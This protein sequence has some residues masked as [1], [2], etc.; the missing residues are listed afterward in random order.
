MSCCFYKGDSLELLRK[1]QSGTIDF[2]YANPP[3]NTTMQPW[4]TKQDWPAIFKE[5]FRILK[6]DGMIALHCSVPFNYELI[7]SAPKPPV[8]SWYWHK[9]GSPTGYLSSNHQPLRV[10][11]EILIF[12]KKKTKYYR[13]Q[14]GEEPHDS[15]TATPTAYTLP[16]APRKKTVVIG[17][18][19]THFLQ[20]KRDV[21]GFST[22]PREMVELMIKSYTKE[23]DTILDPYCYHGLSGVVAKE[24]GRRWIGFDLNF[25]PRLLL[26]S[27]HGT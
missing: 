24:L 12:R 20:M 4:D 13:Q 11:E 21:Q 16:V 23:G 2:I 25:Y 17:K 26:T 3:F 19:R 27:H 8:Y 10:V 14:I 15:Y 9:D 18:T 7:R 5:Y 1:Q 6:D 22:R